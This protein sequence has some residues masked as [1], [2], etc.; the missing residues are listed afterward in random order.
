MDPYN[1]L[2]LK[3]LGLVILQL[4]GEKLKC[5]SL[6][7]GFQPKSGTNMC[8]WTAS[9]VIDFFDRKGCAVY[10]S[11]M[12]LSKAFDMVEWK[13]LFQCLESKQVDPIFLILLQEPVL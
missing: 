8:S 11:A 6:Q 2:L 1:S 4:E 10:G 9:T 7:F 5:D 12:Y 13:E 3:L